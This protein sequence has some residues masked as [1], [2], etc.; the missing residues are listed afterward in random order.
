[1][2][3]NR[4]SSLLV[5]SATILSALFLLASL[6]VARPAS[7]RPA[8]APKHKTGL[9]EHEMQ[10]GYWRADHT[11][12]PALILTN[13]LENTALT[14]TP[15]LYA[16]DGS[17]YDL[18]PLTLGPAGVAIVDIRQS[19]DAAPDDLRAHFSD[20]GSAGV[21]YFWQWAG[22]VDAMVQNRDAK[23]SLNFNFCLRAQAGM[24]HA[25]SVVVQ[26]GLWW[27][28]DEGVI[29]FLGLINVSPRAIQA[30]V[31]VLTESGEVESERR[32]E[33]EAH[34]TQVLDLLKD[35]HGRS[36]GVRV[37][38]AGTG[39]DL[40]L[41]GGLE[42]AQEGYHAQIPFNTIQGG[43]S[44]SAIAVSSVGLMLGTPD[45]RLK[46]PSGTQFGVYLALRNTTEQPV[47]VTPT[48]YYMEGTQVRT[49]V[50]KGLTLAAREAKYLDPGDVS[51]LLGV[52]AFSGMA[53][54]VFTDQGGPSD[55]IISNGSIAQTKKYD[56]QAITRAVGKSQ[57]IGLK[58]WDLSN[59]NDTM[60]SL[61]NLGDNDQD[62]A[63]TFF[64]DGG[65]YWLPVELKSGGSAMVNVSDII[66]MQQPDPDGHLIPP[67]TLHGSA[68]LSGASGYPEWINVGVSVDV[69][70]V[71]TA[72]CGTK[73]P[74]CF[75]Y[76]DFQVQGV[77]STAP[78]GGTATFKA[79]ALG[80]NGVWTDV[81]RGNP[82]NGVIVVWSSDNSNVAT[83]QGAGAFTGVNSGGFNAIANATLL[84]ENPDCPEGYNQPCP[85]SPYV[86]SA[87]GTVTPMVSI[88]CG[89]TDL[90]LGP[91][92]PA[93]TSTGKCTATVSP[94][95]GT[96]SWTVNTNTV[97]LS[98]STSAA[99]NYTAA[100]PS[101]KLGDTTISLTYTANGQSAAAQSQQITVHN[102]TSV[103][104]VSDTTNPTGQACSVKCLA[105]PGDG[106]CNANTSTCNYNCFLRTREYS[107]LDQF[108][109]Q[110][111]NV[112]IPH[113]TW[114]E[115]IPYTTTCPNFTLSL[116]GATV[117][118][119]VLDDFYLC[120]TCCLTNGP[121]CA[122][123]S[124]P[125]QTIT[126][127][128]IQVGT[129][130]IS[131]NCSGATITP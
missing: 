32:V 70:N 24:Q 114:V 37:T 45:A 22:A 31:Q 62:L 96:Y 27:K 106:T 97:S 21:K 33:L 8:A 93:D 121:G 88:S 4:K 16:A 34:E 78:V 65:R 69:I 92:A 79:L 39:R 72:T 40:V 117:S 35:S 118:G 5:A 113:V 86:G 58:D 77:N 101:T 104:V 19:L 111:I 29:G 107:V 82:A 108:Q 116:G 85:S 30:E 90:A 9:A 98:S 102:P 91:T 38:Y 89:P 25:A 3:H 49:S 51:G 130:T 115:T 47:L 6:R 60:I 57:A 129:E 10:G 119:T 12:E 126:V 2:D 15:V 67:G 120:H 94:S 122:W 87:G 53:N 105:N 17:E 26:E 61:L 123:Q 95:G 63:I 74:T 84:D 20:H 18:P 110:L 64:F 128:G 23:R 54:L 7:S 76:S 42:N 100:N 46:F 41:A 59:G 43:Q 50:L 124:N 11:F 127:N 14:V 56:S 109:N 36:G 73:C 13:I 81:T 80:Q 68:V 103:T 52:S 44:P 83:S 75:G 66:G 99:P 125:V 71:S 131:V 28:A 55:V 1:M 48:L 112:G